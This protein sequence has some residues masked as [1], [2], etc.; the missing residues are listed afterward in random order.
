MNKDNFGNLFSEIRIGNVL[1]RNRIVMPPMVTCYAG[2]EGEINEQVITH[3]EVI[4]KGG[5]GLAIVEASYV[6]SSGKGFES[7][8]AVDRD[9]LMPRLHMLTNAV[10]ARGAAIAIQLYHG[11]IQ[12][13]VD[14]PVGPSA[15]GRKVFPPPRTPREL[16]TD[17]VEKM[18]ENFANA[19]LRAKM[20]GFDMVEVHGT[21]GYLI[22]E[23]L[24]PLTNKRTDKYGADRALFATEIVRKIKEKCGSDFSVIFRL[25]ANEFEEG[26]ITLDYAKEVA[27]KLEASGVDAFDVTGGTYDTADHII[28]PI[29]YDKQGYFFREASEIKKIVNVPVISGGMLVDPEIANDAI[30]N[31]LV[32]LV[33]LGRQLIADPEWPKKVREGRIAEIRPCIACE[34][35][36]ERIFFQEPVNCS[37]NPLKSYEYRYLSEEHIPKAKNLK[38]VIVV[39][40]GLAGLEAARVASLRGHNVVLFEESN[41]LGGVLRYVLNEKMKWRIKR[42]IEWY[43]CVLCNQDIEVKLNTKVDADIIQ[44]ENPDVVILATGS[45]PLIPKIPG[46]ENAVL[47][48][49]VLSGKTQPG[50]SVII[51]G[52]GLVGCELAI[53]L[54]NEGHDVTII[55]ALPQ[56]AMGEPILSRMGIIKLLDKAEVRVLTCAPVVEIHKSGVETVNN[57][58]IRSLFKADTIILSVGRKAKVETDLIEAS[59]KVAR[60]VYL[61]GDAK[62]PRKIIDAIR[63]G[64]WTG[65]SI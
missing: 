59:K 36:I 39:G 55:E 43:G 31:G 14:Q 46:V 7:E 62:Q 15:I 28:P 51:I 17:E 23:F 32:D 8:I 50:K 40:G 37:V 6:H 22:A 65:V 26:G 44:K 64:F 29:Y 57:L 42:L 18:V 2:P 52:G 58:G 49:D 33:F 47:A 30:G 61:I 9:G 24:S 56:L 38:K 35:C 3:Y 54:S 19:A 10:K 48:E 1:L 5:I 12:A 53:K 13:H 4:A 21:H 60:E 63:E 41:D 11:G 27:K 25:A 34:Q 45:D 16:T 20:S